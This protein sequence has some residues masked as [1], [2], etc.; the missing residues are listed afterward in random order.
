MPILLRCNE[1]RIGFSAGREGAEAVP[2]TRYH[3]LR[4]WMNGAGRRLTGFTHE[5]PV[6]MP[7]VIGYVW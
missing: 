6:P 3:G 4:P 7:F 5:A 1:T 2:V